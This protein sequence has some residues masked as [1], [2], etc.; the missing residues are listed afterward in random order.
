MAV[1]HT[2]M[3]KTPTEPSSRNWKEL[4]G[5]WNGR[6]IETSCEHLGVPEAA[7]LSKSNQAARI[8]QVTFYII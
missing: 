8:H 7:K 4:F 5:P 1:E 3:T 6:R 2:F